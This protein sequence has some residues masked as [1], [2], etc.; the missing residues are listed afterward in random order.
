MFLIAYFYRGGD[1]DD[2]ADAAGGMRH[3]KYRCGGGAEHGGGVRGAA[4]RPPGGAGDRGGGR[5]RAA[6]VLRHHPAGD[7]GETVRV[8]P[9]DAA[10]GGV[11]GRHFMKTK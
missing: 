8:E 1:A 6:Q 3:G 11:R 5:V 10:I 2:D 9:G 7:V 4:Q